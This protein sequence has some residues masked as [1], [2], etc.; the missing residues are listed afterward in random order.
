MYKITYRLTAEQAQCAFGWLSDDPRINQ[1]QTILL[2]AIE[3]SVVTLDSTI[4]THPQLN[5]TE[6]ADHMYKNPASL[7]L[8][9]AFSV[10]GGNLI[11][12]NGNVGGTMMTWIQNLFEFLK[13]NG[14]ICKLSKISQDSNKT[15]ARF[16]TRKNMVLQSITWTE[17]LLSM[18]FNFNFV[19]VQLAKIQEYHVDQSDSFLPSIDV[20]QS[21][22]FTQEVLNWNEI[23]DLVIAIGIETKFIDPRIVEQAMGT[24]GIYSGIGL[25]ASGVAVYYMASLAGGVSSIPVAGWIVAGVIAL[26]IIGFGVYQAIHQAML[27]KKFKEDQIKYFGDD[28][29]DKEQVERFN[30]FISNISKQIVRLDESI[31]A[32]SM[33]LTDPCQFYVNFEN[34]YYLCEV[35]NSAPQGSYV[36]TI[37][38]GGRKPFHAFVLKDIDGNPLGKWVQIETAY[39]DLSQCNSAQCIYR[40]PYTGSYVYLLRKHIYKPFTGGGRRFDDPS[41][42][43]YGNLT[44]DHPTDTYY[45]VA[46]KIAPENFT[47]VIREIVLEAIMR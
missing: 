21:I 46:T 42:T 10:Y 13:D 45:L 33:T 31:T 9:G 18:S 44:I 43:T 47:N 14:I 11:D 32:Y 12:T 16:K 30:N 28:V 2:D 23:L 20:L 8:S 34:N 17:K 27:S 19:E 5:G 22:S 7:G 37:Q 15:A 36:G 1:L 6:V 4:S 3:D 24:V 40:L 41:V 39:S 25:A 35:Q 38:Y 29:K 26:A